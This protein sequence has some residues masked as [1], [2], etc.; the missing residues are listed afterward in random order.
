MD[1]KFE[2]SEKKNEEKKIKKEVS[3]NLKKINQ[4]I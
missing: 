3:Q 2:K 1:E 4:F